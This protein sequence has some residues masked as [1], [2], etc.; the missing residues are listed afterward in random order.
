MPGAG[1]AFE[2]LDQFDVGGAA[3]AD[4]G[5]LALEFA[6]GD[7]AEALLLAV[8]VC[9]RREVEEAVQDP[10]TCASSG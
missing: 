8:R 4:D 5:L 1:L 2:F 10:R 6:R 9:V 3:L 7:L